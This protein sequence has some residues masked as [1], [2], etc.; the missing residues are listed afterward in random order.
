LT[1]RSGCRRII[2]SRSLDRLRHIVAN[3]VF[4]GEPGV[5]ANLFSVRGLETE[6]TPDSVRSLFSAYGEFEEAAVIVDRATGK[7]K[8]YGFI[9]FRH[10][11]GALRSLKEPSKKT[12]GRMT[13]TQLAAAGNAG[14]GATPSADVSLLKIYVVNVPA[15]S[16]RIAFSPISPLMERSR[17]G[18]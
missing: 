14:T 10:V 1:F 13:V 15:D 17:R 5:V 8:G 16:R 7:S 2:E 3:A 6:T 18:R 4:R 9:T 12:D 11:D